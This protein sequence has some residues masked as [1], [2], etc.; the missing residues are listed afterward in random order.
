M[1][2]FL[3]FLLCIIL[4]STCINNFALADSKDVT[5]EP[6]PADLEMRFALS[7]LPAALRA[8]ANVYLL[9]PKQGYKLTHK[10]NSKLECLVERTAWEWADY[11]NDIYIPLCYDANGANYHLKVIRDA[12][13]MRATGMDAIALKKEIERR[14]KSGMYSAPAKA[15]LSYMV[16]PVMRANGPPDMQVHTMTM[17]HLMFY[18]PN[19]TNE[20]IGAK[21]NLLDPESLRIP[22]IDKQG[23]SQQS[24]MIQMIGEA[25]KVKIVANEKELITTLCA[26]RDVLCLT[27][28]HH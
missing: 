20:N 3:R 25:E 19:I 28:M 6:M 17:P 24:Y 2:I 12:A 15:G 13:Q 10:G 14:Y 16:S 1:N 21:P 26:Y 22:F 4:T 7:A 18:A 8:D 5:L 9:D 27:E 11:R 23:I